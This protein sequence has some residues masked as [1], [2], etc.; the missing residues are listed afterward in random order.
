[1]KTLK[2]E[3]CI[4]VNMIALDA[5]GGYMDIALLELSYVISTDVVDPT[6][7][8]LL[9]AQL[10]QNVGFA[11]INIFIENMLNNNILITA[12]GAKEMGEKIDIFE[13]NIVMLPDLTEV[14]LLAALYAKFNSI[15]AENT[16]VKALSLRNVRDN[17]TYSYEIDED[18]EVDNM[19]L[20]TAKEWLGE[21]PYWEN[22]WWERNDIS[23]YDKA[24]ETEEEL[25]KWKKY[26][27]ESK[28][29]E[30]NK[31]TFEEI[32][33]EVGAVFQRVVNSI[34]KGQAS[35]ELIEVD[36]TRGK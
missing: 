32:E 27:A 3:K 34:N 21:Y 9:Q 19:E 24:A 6:E 23:T 15:T 4:P 22:T 11:K 5:E 7:E 28:I 25:N 26:A 29:D 1:M 12:E 14:T 33:E 20:P 10:D 36:F 8:I 18:D 31:Q 30:L 35:G 16:S 17:V 13:N 2:M